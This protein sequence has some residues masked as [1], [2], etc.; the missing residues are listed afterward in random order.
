[1]NDIDKG[2]KVE[3][4]NLTPLLPKFPTTRFQ[5][6]KRKILP[7]LRNLIDTIECKS[8]I[9]LFSGSGIV[10]LL[11]RHIGKTVISNDFLLYNQNTANVFLTLNKNDIDIKNIENELYG[12]LNNSPLSDLAYVA[13]NYKGIYFK[14]EENIQI[15]RFCQNIMNVES[16]YKELYIYAVGQSL[17]KKRPYNLFHRANLNMRL[18]DVP[19]S[20]G[21]AKTWETSIYDHAIKCIKELMKFPINGNNDR[22]LML[23]HNS[24][25]LILF[26][27][28]VDVVYLDPP[29]INGKGTSVDYSDFYHF[30]EGL[31]DYEVFKDG[32]VSYPHKPINK[33]TS[34]WLDPYNAKIELENICKYWNKSTIVM[35][36]RSDGL[37]SPEEIKSIMSINNRTVEMHSAGEY[38]YALST[39]KTN[40][41]LFIISKP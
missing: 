11:F 29:Y 39:N 5:G 34:A 40:E 9:D 4:F 14:D 22:H 27:K 30:L 38:Q 20:F 13:D 10:S 3:D 35:S 17:I 33:K 41:E 36:Y 21:N 16:P 32:D 31:I 6:S 2:T 26:P 25:S 1:M 12:L 28:D 7:E 24:D 23:N 18:K 19:R 8:I 37:P 15:D